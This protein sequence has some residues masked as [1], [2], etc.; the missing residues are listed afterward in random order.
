M[1]RP[2]CRVYPIQSSP[3]KATP[4]PS[5]EQKRRGSELRLWSPII[6]SMATAR[7]LKA[8]N[9]LMAGAIR[10]TQ[11]SSMHTLN[12]ILHSVAF[13]KQVKF[14]DV[15]SQSLIVKYQVGVMQQLKPYQLRQILTPRHCKVCSYDGLPVSITHGIV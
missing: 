15:I 3:K 10:Y 5:I 4:G 6:S 2:L 12:T 8:Y 1:Q 11:I 13:K 7:S 9:I 14:T